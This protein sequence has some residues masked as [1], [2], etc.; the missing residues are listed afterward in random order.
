M[1]VKEKLLDKQSKYTMYTIFYDAFKRSKNVD[2][3]QNTRGNTEGAFSDWAG[4]KKKKERKSS[5]MLE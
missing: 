1:K 3:T 2:V 4:K 5:A